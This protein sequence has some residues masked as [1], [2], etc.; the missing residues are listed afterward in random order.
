VCRIRSAEDFVSLLA[1]QRR[2]A[3]DATRRRHAF[4]GR[5]CTYGAEL[6]ETI[7]PSAVPRFSER[8]AALPA[9]VRM[10]PAPVEQRLE[11]SRSSFAVFD[12]SALSSRKKRVHRLLPVRSRRARRHRM[13]L[14][15]RLQRA[16]A[17]GSDTRERRRSVRRPRPP[18]P[19]AARLE[20]DQLHAVE[21]ARSRD[22]P[23]RADPLA[24]T[25]SP[26]PGAGDAMRKLDDG[27]G[28]TPAASFMLASR[29]EGGA[30]EL[31]HQQI[32]GRIDRPTPLEYVYSHGSRRSGPAG[33]SLR[34][35]RRLAASC[36]VIDRSSSVG[37]RR[38]QRLRHCKR[39]IVRPARG[40]NSARSAGWAGLQYRPRIGH[41]KPRSIR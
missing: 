23:A 15:A 28:Q 3:L 37:S 39:P 19:G 38:K 5:T 12:C 24:R 27:N 7:W 4:D 30:V 20:P 36:R 2:A 16:A 8:L 21:A 25:R 26:T 17:F 40:R 18:S 35:D 32:L 6:S 31:R 9:C 41:P 29:P 10:P 33:R 22:R 34:R 14:T 1:P 13:R 11:Q